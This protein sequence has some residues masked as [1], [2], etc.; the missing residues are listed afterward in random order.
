MDFLEDIYEVAVQ[1]MS[2]TVIWIII[3]VF[4]FKFLKDQIENA[5]KL[6]LLVGVILAWFFNSFGI[7]DYIMEILNELTYGMF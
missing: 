6:S 2:P 4:I 5:I 7:R 1:Y 3:S